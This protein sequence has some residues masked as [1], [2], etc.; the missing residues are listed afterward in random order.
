MWWPQAQRRG[1]A[2]CRRAAHNRGGHESV[3]EGCRQCQRRGDGGGTSLQRA[4][5]RGDGAA[6]A[7]RGG[8][9]AARGVAVEWWAGG[10][11]RGGWAAGGRRGRG[12]GVAGA[13]GGTGR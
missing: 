13:R 11:G 4:D 9:R 6:L 2:V 3:G 1:C 10:V 5:G 7:R 12:G 8:G